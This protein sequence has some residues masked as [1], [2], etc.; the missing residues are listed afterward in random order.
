[1]EAQK[2]LQLLLEDRKM[3]LIEVTDL[4]WSHVNHRECDP[5]QPKETTVQHKSILSSN[6]DILAYE[7]VR[8]I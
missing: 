1:M 8:K 4:H 7:N 5:N 3:K 2:F 6:Y